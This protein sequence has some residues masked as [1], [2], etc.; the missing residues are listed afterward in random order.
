MSDL[1][2]KIP[3]GSPL[4]YHLYSR[5]H[6]P[7]NFD[8]FFNEVQKYQVSLKKSKEKAGRGMEGEF[9]GDGWAGS[10]DQ[11]SNGS[12]SWGG[13][14]E[15]STWDGGSAGGTEFSPYDLTRGRI[16]RRR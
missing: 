13:S 14:W 5:D 1:K 6:E 4:R 10:F 7:I 2:K 15:T 9:S 8:S 3:L 16:T 11:D 12:E